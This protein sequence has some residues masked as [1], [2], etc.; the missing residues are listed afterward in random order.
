MKKSEID[1]F[2]LSG[3]LDAIADRIAALEAQNK[4]LLEA[5]EDALE[6]YEDLSTDDYSHEKDKDVR[7]EMRAAISKA[8]QS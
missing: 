5:L 3:D 4:E 7:D 2:V 1:N 6:C 8:R